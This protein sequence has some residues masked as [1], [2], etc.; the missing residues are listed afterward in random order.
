[1]ATGTDILVEEHQRLS[2]AWLEAEQARVD[3][4]AKLIQEYGHKCTMDYPYNL[5]KGYDEALAKAAA[6]SRDYVQ[7]LA[8]QGFPSR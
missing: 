5:F 7:W 2:Q 6:A 8:Q 3:V 1:M 4:L